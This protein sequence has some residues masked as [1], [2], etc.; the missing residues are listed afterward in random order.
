M[1]EKNLT[2]WQKQPSKLNIQG[3]IEKAIESITGE[4]IELNASGRTDA[5]VHALGQVANFKT[6]SSIPI[7]K[8]AI[9][10]NSKLKKSIRIHK[11]EEV[12]EN[13]HSRLSC[14][15]KTYR[16]VINNSEVGTAIY[17]NLETHIPKKL[18]VNKMK[19][20]VKYFE[21]EHDFKAFKASGTSSKS[22]VRTIYKADVYNVEDKIMIE[23]TGNGFLYN[24][25]RIISG[26]LLEVGLG[27]I[28]PEEIT[29]IIETGKRENAGKTLPAHGLYLV[30]VNY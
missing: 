7:E 13:F 15:R 25:V 2:G 20:A 17:R 9:A 11:A 6:N 23:L 1:T 8:M 28:Q 22:S 4:E 18:D 24:M 5:G 14:K 10:I 30:E 3:T 16:Y 21:G 27:K 26:T 29:G 19:E 12:D